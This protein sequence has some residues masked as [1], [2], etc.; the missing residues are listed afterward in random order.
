MIGIDPHGNSL[1]AELRANLGDFLRG[2]AGFCAEDHA[3]DSAAESRADIFEIPHPAAELAGNVYGGADFFDRGQVRGDARKC[4]VEV[5]E[6]EPVG[7]RVLPF[8]C[9]GDRVGRIHG[10][11]GGKPALEAHDFPAHQVNGWQQDHKVDKKFRN[12][13]SPAPWL[14]SGWNC[15]A[16]SGP[17]E[18]LAAKGSP[19]SQVELASPGS[20]GAGKN[21][22]TK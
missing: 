19:Y 5:H 9:E 10:F 8:F 7:P 22:C 2:F 3:A 21:E 6:M 17:H 1:P 13:A 4:G 18:M 14:F 11:F 16:C 15:V 20:S 12:T